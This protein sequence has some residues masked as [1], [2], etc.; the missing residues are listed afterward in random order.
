MPLIATKQDGTKVTLWAKMDTGA[1]KNFISPS[2]IARMGRT[3]ELKEHN[4]D[5]IHEIDGNLFPTKHVIRLN[6]F[7]G[8]S[9]QPFSQMFF[10]VD[11]KAGAHQVDPTGCADLP[12]E[13]TDIP[14]ILL[15]EPFFKDSHA[16]LI[17]PN[18]ENQ[19]NPDYEVLAS[20]PKAGLSSCYFLGTKGAVPP[21]PSRGLV[22]TPAPIRP[23]ITG[24]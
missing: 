7:A 22:K 2:L 23:S 1:D 13:S 14:D 16:L 18:F 15:G 9:N 21:V 20:L 12:N 5:L 4:G 10:I 19:A 3:S 6:F 8:L 17:D 11:P 24:R